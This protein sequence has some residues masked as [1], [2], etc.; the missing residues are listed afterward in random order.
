MQLRGVVVTGQGQGSHFTA[1]AW[2]REQFIEKLGIAPHPGTLNLR[3]Q[4]P[5]SRRS[6]AELRRGPG[7]MIR[8]GEPGACDARC[9]H[10]NLKDAETVAIVW[11]QVD[12]YPDDQVELI[13][14]FPLRQAFGLLD[15]SEVIVEV[16][17]PA[18][19]LRRTVQA[20]LAAHNVLSLATH[21]P[22]GPWAASVFY[23]HIGWTL[24]F[25]SAPGT[26]H[27]Q[28]LAAAPHVAATIN[29]DYSD[30]REIRGVQLE[31]TAA[32]V[33]SNR[34]RATG[35]SAY[36]SKYPFLDQA[37]ETSL[38][39]ALERVQLYRII[40]SRLLFADNSKGFGHRAEVDIRD[41]ST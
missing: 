33:T 6:W 12:S 2:A 27:S 19:A 30:W 35:L 24:Y 18:E 25:L 14:D 39:Q 11:P 16:R 31:G 1:L 3:L 26:Q 38:E 32:P 21:G 13:A 37:T 22:E 5:A 28:N 10:V 20:Y 7:E 36:R 41:Q 15:G 23:V 40:P 17:P 4:G 34:E 8:A 29:P 9:Y